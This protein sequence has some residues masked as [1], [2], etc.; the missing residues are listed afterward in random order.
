MEKL[1]Q[2]QIIGLTLKEYRIQ[3]GFSQAELA[4]KLGF[5]P[6]TI[7]KYEKEGIN[8]INLVRYMEQKLGIDL[9]NYPDEIS[10]IKKMFEENHIKILVFDECLKELKNMILS[11]EETKLIELSFLKTLEKYINLN[12]NIN[13]GKYSYYELN[14]MF[15]ALKEIYFKL[16]TSN[17]DNKFNYYYGN[18]VSDLISFILN[19]YRKLYNSSLECIYI[20]IS[21]ITFNDFHSKGHKRINLKDIDLILLDVLSIEMDSYDKAACHFLLKAILYYLIENKELDDQYKN[22]ENVSK[23]LF[24]GKINEEYLHSPTPL[25]KLFSKVEADN[26][27]S[28]AVKYYK[29]FKISSLREQQR[30]IVHCLYGLDIYINTKNKSNDD[31]FTNILSLIK[32]FTSKEKIDIM[33]QQFDSE[34]YRLLTK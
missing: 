28:P 10:K 22:L 14:N 4:E 34:L 2:S 6:N 25:D 7:C 1:K 12:D 29:S 23:L 26:S 17:D 31:L 24:A 30:S 32:P 16:E 18:F 33:S 3:N 13:Y 8:D 20:N 27:N 19:V 9:L 11:Q 15:Q 21:K 5:A